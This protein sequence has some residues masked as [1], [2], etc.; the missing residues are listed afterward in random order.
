MIDQ[1]DWRTAPKALRLRYARGLLIAFW[2][3]EWARRSREQANAVD[4]LPAGI[5]LGDGGRAEGGVPR[6]ATDDRAASVSATVRW[7]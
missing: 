5:V 3:E 2:C 6:H 4:D 7:P 1:P